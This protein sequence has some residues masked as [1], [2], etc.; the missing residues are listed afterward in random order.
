MD[1][2][3][4]LTHDND[5]EVAYAAIMALGFIGAGTNH[6]RIAALLRQLSAFYAKDSSG[7]FAVR[8]AQG[9]LHMGKGLVS[10]SN[11]VILCIYIYRYRYI[12]MLDIR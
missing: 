12:E 2:V 3:S 10:S 7:L 5:R 1:L 11:V 6:A 8:I 9:I 4:K